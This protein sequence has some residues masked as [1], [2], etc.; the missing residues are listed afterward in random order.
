MK[1]EIV[2]NMDR[3]EGRVMTFCVTLES[4]EVSAVCRAG[5]MSEKYIATLVRDAVRGAVDSLIDKGLRGLQTDELH[6]NGSI[7]IGRPVLL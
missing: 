3:R 4:L 1:A 5:N 7:E 2:L 6:A